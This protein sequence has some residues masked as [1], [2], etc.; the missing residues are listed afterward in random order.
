M[1]LK[2]LFFFVA[3]LALIPGLKAQEREYSF[4]KDTV[5]FTRDKLP[6][7]Y[8]VDTRID[9]MGYWRK[10]V[11]A[12]LVTVAPDAPVP[13]PVYKSSK[14]MGARAV[15]EDSPDIPVTESSTTQ[16]ENSI[17]VSVNGTPWVLNSNNSTPHPS[18]G[19]IYGAD[20]FYS[21]DEGASW[22]GQYQ[23]AGGGN[24]GDPVAIINRSGRWFVGFIANSG[25]QS[26]AFSDNQGTSWTVKSV[27]SGAS[28]FLDK[29]HLW[30]DRGETSPYEGYLYDAWMGTSGEIRIARST[31]DGSTWSSATNISAGTSAGSHN[32]GV[33][34]KSGPNGEVYAAW[35]VYDS[36]PSDEKAIGF[37]RSLDGGATWEPGFRA[38]NNI[39]GIRNH[40]TDQNMRTNS[41]PSMT[42]D[43]SDGPNKGT[44]YVVWANVNTPGVNTGA[45]IEVYMIKSTD[46]GT[47]WSTPVKVNT[48][49]MGTG[50]QHFFPWIA[51]DAANG[52]LAVVFYDNRNVNANQ[53]EAWSAVSTDGGATWIDFRVS[54]VAFTPQ[55]IP[56]MAASYFGDYLAIDMHDG[57]VYPCWTDNRSGHALTYVSPYYLSG[58]VN[59]P[60]VAYNSHTISD[61]NPGNNNGQL[62]YGESIFMGLTMENIGSDPDTNVMVTLSTTSP[63]I[64]MLDST[65]DYGNFESEEIKFIADGFHFMVA[66][67]VPNDYEVEF[68]VKAVDK[69]DSVFISGFK[70][71]A[72]APQL[73]INGLSISDPTGN[74]NNAL[75]PGETAQ[76]TISYTNIGQ[77]PISS[78]ISHLSTLQTFV[79]IANPA[80]TMTDIPVGGSGSATFN[81]SVASVPF[82]SAVLLQN[83]VNHNGQYSAEKSFAESIGLIVED[84]ETGDFNKFSW[85]MPAAN[86]F[87]LDNVSPYEGIYS[88]RNKAI[89]N[90]DSAVLQINYA[91]M[92]DDSISFF[93]K[94]SSELLQDKLEFYVDGMRLGQWSGNTSWKRFVYPVKAGAHTFKWVYV[95]NASNAVGQ[96]AAWIDFIL[97]PPEQKSMAYAGNDITICEDQIVHLSGSADYYNT[98]LW[99]TSGSGHFSDATILNPDYTPSAADI[100]AGAVTLTLTANGPGYKSTVSDQITVTFNLK[101]TAFAGT[102]ASVCAGNAYQLA[103]ASATSY[104]SLLW[105][106][107]GTG[108][109]DNTASVN[110]V[111]TPGVS[112]VTAG[113]VS[114]TL[115]AE[116]GNTCGAV[117]D[118]VDLV[119]NPLP[120]LLLSG[121]GAICAGDSIMLSYHFTGTAPF[122]VVFADESTQVFDVPHAEVWMHPASNTTYAVTKVTDA[123]G[124]FADVTASVAVTV[125]PLPVLDLPSEAATCGSR[126]IVLDPHAQGAS[127]YLWMP[128]GQT[129]ATI[130]VDSTGF[131]LGDQEFSVKATSANG[132][133]ASKTIT[134]NFYDCTGFDEEAGNVLFK[135][136]PNPNRGEFYVSFASQQPE[137]V[138]MQLV[139][140]NGAIVYTDDKI[141]VGGSTMKKVSVKKAAAGIYLLHIINNNVEVTKEIVITK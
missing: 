30:V 2:L 119:I 11:E 6:A 73:Q 1:K 33:N 95:K 123:H 114:L 103:D 92:Y 49:P 93:R 115:T 31:D 109:F 100:A 137:S 94:T 13:A 47:T 140:A 60:F 135:I 71:I 26:V 78:A 53:A 54:D 101:P 17:A 83:L 112:D 75:D 62:D 130:Q 127:T 88:A 59:G 39:R 138:K 121:D 44:I 18:T 99:T 131:G 20:A 113:F 41:F 25:G 98:L 8:K 82:G 56:N 126:A 104:Q 141:L 84:W 79:S 51:C 28:G 22:A 34:I 16:S 85:E 19:S 57:M 9:N 48:D 124:C 91:V 43:L 46:K 134:V 32:Q 27:A 107:T 61:I 125:N 118:Q 29:N 77:F 70:I 66:D 12:G 72:H 90:S 136:Y 55:P 74:N 21:D 81:V 24:S 68:E 110:P 50:K 69:N 139:S 87:I 14:I 86:G 96:D 4:E 58:T 5:K 108:S 65:E 76:V 15:Y 97:F 7:D 132:C 36:W 42:V 63:Y 133:A 35:A 23:G 40:E 37:A 52:N 128:G 129:T 117:T 64:T 67:N 102:D 10:M 80:V 106:T 122:T 111:F 120:S 45:G 116:S 105:S 89:G 38:L 3:A